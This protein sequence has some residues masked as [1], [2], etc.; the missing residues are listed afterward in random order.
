[1]CLTREDF[2]VLLDHDSRYFSFFCVYDV[3]VLVRGWS[4]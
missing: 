4:Q 1:M 2:D 3:I